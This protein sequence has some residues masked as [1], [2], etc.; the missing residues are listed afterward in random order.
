[1]ALVSLA[2]GDVGSDELAGMAVLLLAATLAEA[3][4]VPIEGVAVGSTSLA[5]IFIVAAAV[6]YGG[7]AAAVVGFLT[8]TLVEVGRRRPPSRVVFNCAVYALAG[9]AAGAAAGAVGKDSLGGL[10]VGAVLA[11]VSFYAVDITHREHFRKSY[12]EPL[13][14]AGWLERTIPD[15]PTSPNQKY[16]LPPKGRAWL[17]TNA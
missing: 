10:V 7:P 4:P 17:T 9:T 14:E 6:I 12:L 1:M 5:T 15:K 8:M 3:F 16:R 11:A 13:V 2:T